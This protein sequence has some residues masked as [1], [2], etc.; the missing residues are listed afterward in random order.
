MFDCWPEAR[1]GFGRFVSVF[2]PLW[3]HA[4]G[5]GRGCTSGHEIDDGSR[6][7]YVTINDP[8]GAFEGLL[9]EWAHV[10]LWTLGVELETHDGLLLDHADD[11]MFVSPIRRDCMRPMSA[12][13]HG[14]LAWVMYTQGDL[15]LA[16][17][18]GHADEVRGV[19]RWN[20]PKLEEGIITFR[21][22][23]RWTDWGGGFGEALI[24][25]AEQVVEDGWAFVG[26]EN[27]DAALAAHR[28]WVRGTGVPRSPLHDGEEAA[29]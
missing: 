22:Q 13:L 16:A 3:D 27:R 29:S 9:H 10:R 18:D 6:C 11:E 12:C 21:T 8:Y 24:G 1:D 5:E 17:A 28:S 25:W 2:W 23:A 15:K 19:V 14:L 4:A 26:R 7:V 20:L